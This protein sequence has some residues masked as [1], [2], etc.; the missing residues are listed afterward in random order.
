[1]IHELDL[2]IAENNIA[3]GAI[4]LLKIICPEWDEKCIKFKTFTD[5]I[6]NKLVGCYLES[7]PDHLV[8]VRI[9]GKNTD[10]LIDRKAEVATMKK[11][12]QIKCAAPL[13]ATFRNGICY[14]FVDGETIDEDTVRHETVRRLIAQTFVK[15]HRL[16]PDNGEKPKPLLF[17]ILKQYCNLIPSNFQD[18]IM[19]ERYHKYIPTKDD[20]TNEIRILEEHLTRLRSPVVF[21]HNDALLKNVIYDSKRE[22]V[23]FIDYEYA[24]FNY[25]A[26]DIGNHFC[27]FAGVTDTDFSRYP[28]REFQLKWLRTYLECWHCSNDSTISPSVVTDELLETL[29]V[30]VNKFALASNL[31][32]GLW[33]VVQAHNSTIHFDFLGFAIARFTEYFAR[34]ADF[35]A[36][37]MPE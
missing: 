23:T 9:Y 21:C 11:L 28:D 22:R 35:L 12:A 31:V 25:Q 14:G 37:R 33:G 34:K 4:Q 15:F 8:L 2:T 13:Y 5:G 32:W 6:T 20:L 7:N 30:Q 17:P 19:N 36:L 10:L 1:M 18:Q 29:Y 27:E 26:F 24:G 16:P 3:R